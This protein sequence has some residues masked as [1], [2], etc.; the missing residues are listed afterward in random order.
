MKKQVTI[1]GSTGSI[2][3]QA[4]DVV[5]NHPERFGIEVLSA[6]NNCDLLINQAVEFKPNAVVI[7]NPE[8]YQRLRDELKHLPVK[9]FAG[10]DAIAQIVEMEGP[11]IILNALV[12]FAG[13]IPTYQ[14]VKSGKPVALAN[15]ESLVIAGELIMAEAIRNHTP[16]IPVDSEHS[17]IFQ[18]LVGETM[19]SVE[20]IY[21]TA[22]GGPF[23][24]KSR[25]EVEQ[26]GIL[27]ALN[28]PNWTMGSK[29]TIDS[30]TMMNKGLEVIEAHWLFGLSPEQIEVVIH[31]QSVIHSI[32]QFADGSM[33]AQLGVPDMRLPILYA[34]GFPERIPADLPR[35]NF[36]DYPMLTF[37]QPDRE[38]FRNLPLAYRTLEAGGNASCILNAANETAVQAFLDGRIPF[39]GIPSVI[40]LCLESIP[41]LRQP[42][43]NDLLTTHY[44]TTEKAIQIISEQS[45]KS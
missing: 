27:E 38:L 37:E 43:L 4:L 39:M 2:G 36:A 15:K 22:S 1:L 24:G 34:L 33:K 40:E 17:A 35:L 26:A 9:V 31:P 7:G 8:Y 6:Q 44:Q 14:A 28:H 13:M 45:W 20:K 3:K 23:R 5:R 10:Q 11:D 16:I 29:I 19:R 21:L 32:V 25:I 30:A 12:G 41:H 42:G 18:C